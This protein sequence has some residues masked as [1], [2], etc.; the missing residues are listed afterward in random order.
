AE[1]HNC[2]GP[3]Q[4]AVRHG[5]PDQVMA[6]YAADVAGRVDGV[7]VTHLDTWRSLT[8][9][10]LATTYEGLD[11]LPRPA[12]LAEQIALTSALLA[13]TPQ[14]EPWPPGGAFDDG[15]P[16][17]ALH[18]APLAASATGP[19]RVDLRWTDIVQTA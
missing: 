18:R 11:R 7:V 4:G 10:R 12:T 6:R 13:T 19:T 2:S 1:A 15:E 14:L 17:A 16:W 9:G 8:G 3:W 5:W